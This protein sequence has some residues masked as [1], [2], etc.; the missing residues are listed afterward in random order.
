MFLEFSD[1][2][3]HQ[4]LFLDYLY[5]FDN[6]Q[7]YY[8]KNFRNTSE[9]ENTFNEIARNNKQH[10]EIL[11]KIIQE[12][13]KDFKLSKQTQLNI[14]NLTSEKCITVLT[15]Q[16]LG[17]L[18]GP[19]YSFYKTITAIKLANSLK[20]KFD[21]YK[22][23]P[24]FWLAGDDHDF[25]E[26][27]SIN[28]LNKENIVQSIRYDDAKPDELNRGSVG[29]LKLKKGIQSFLSELK[30]S[31]RETEFS[32][33]LFVFLNSIYKEGI[34]FKDAF[35]KLLFK[36]F[37]EY[38]LI[39]FDPQDI[40]VKKILSPLFQ[41]EVLD[42]RIQ[43]KELVEVSAE[44]EEVYHAQVKVKPINLF[45]NEKDGRYLLEPVEDKFRL[46]GKRKTFTEEEIL[47]RIQNHPDDFSPNVLLR[48]VCQDYLFPTA[49]YVG[50]PSEV[51]YFAQAGTLYDFYKIPR[52]FVYPRSSLTIIEKPIQKIITKYNL[53]YYDIFIGKDLLNRK[54]MGELAEINLEDLFENSKNEIDA[55]MD[56]LREKLFAIDP[57]LNDSVLKTRDKVFQSFNSLKAKSDAAQKR[58]H[59]DSFRQIKKLRNF[60]FPLEDLQERE[61]N[62]VYFA[63]KYGLDFVKLIFNE[64]QIN[65]FAHQ[66]LEL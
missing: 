13:Y 37:D 41:K 45:V 51:S 34:T 5:E 56:N 57:T 58:Q 46:K 63:N 48:P 36:L 2:P 14:D 23:V 25:E 66:I 38:G 32:D 31:L 54:I 61:L 65:K 11:H 20:E 39:I 40:E 15:G 62:F 50:G 18:G 7:K 19:L 30:S 47:E 17:I 44:L 21:N 6:V 24:V 8:L 10:K 52:P 16:Q 1:I 27:R 12:Q 49:F 53:N 60:V 9:Y 33:E 64:L 42:Y 26:I 4:N 22:F 35:R 28:I 59:N 3:N 29:N 55:V 43:S